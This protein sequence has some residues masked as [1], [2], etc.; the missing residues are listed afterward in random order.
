MTPLELA[1]ARL[2]ELGE[3]HDAARPAAVS[4]LWRFGAFAG[5]G[6]LTGVAVARRGRAP[7]GGAVIVTRLAAA[8]A[9]WLLPMLLKR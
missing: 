8:V 9:P 1:K 5:L 4:P 3:R 7:V 6:V 2:L